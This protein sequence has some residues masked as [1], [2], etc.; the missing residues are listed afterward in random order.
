MSVCRKRAN[1]RP[2]A[3]SL[4]VNCAPICRSSVSSSIVDIASKWTEDYGSVFCV[5][6]G[7]QLV[8]ALN[9][10]EVAYEAMT[11]S[12][13]AGRPFVA[14]LQLLSGGGNNIGQSQMGP[15]LRLH[16]KLATKALRYTLEDSDFQKIRKINDDIVFDYG[17]GMV[18]DIVPGLRH[19]YPTQKYRK[20]AQDIGFLQNF[21]GWQ[22]LDLH[23]KNFTEGNITD[24]IDFMI[25]ARKEAEKGGDPEEIEM[26][27]DVY[28][29]MDVVDLFTA[30]TDTTRSTLNWMIKYLSLYPDKQDKLRAE[31]NA[32]IGRER[33]PLAADRTKLPY[34]ESVMLETMRV[35]PPL[36]FALV[37]AAT[38]DT[39]VGEYDIP[40]GAIIG[41]NV[42]T[43][44][45]NP[46]IWLNAEEFS[47]ERF[48]TADEKL[49]PRP[50]SWLAFGTGTRVC[51]GEN[52][53][54]TELITILAC[55]IQNFRFR[56]PDGVKNLDMTPGGCAFVHT[57]LPYEVIIEKIN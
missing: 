18:E 6:F 9:S 55:L 48:L 12:D 56:L 14:S 25:Q 36:P 20:T 3:E 49:D 27:K 53:A 11:K 22:Q 15:K 43:I 29:V 4:T 32:V 26:L 1:K 47:P 24:F 7:P 33:L 42:W 5:Y 41:L 31:I 17:N 45:H 35:R 2:I 51:L 39:K 38:C 21:F 19:V 8:V 13:M 23:K 54:K 57:P 16:R 34:C 50:R 52:S 44:H 40:K 28:I 10:V 37:H 46:K 30:G